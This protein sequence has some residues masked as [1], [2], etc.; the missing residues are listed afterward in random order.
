MARWKIGRKRKKY[1]RK[2]KITYRWIELNLV[3]NVH[4]ANTE[5]RIRKKKKYSKKNTSL[6]I[7]DP[8]PFEDFLSSFYFFLFSFLY[9]FTIDTFIDVNDNKIRNK[10]RDLKKMKGKRKEIPLFALHKYRGR[11]AV[12][13]MHWSVTAS[14]HAYKI[15]DKVRTQECTII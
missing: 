6:S 1:R 8:I 10:R 11:H 5:I 14:E 7:F 2:K 3:S 13:E 9:V 12:I 15:C 4:T